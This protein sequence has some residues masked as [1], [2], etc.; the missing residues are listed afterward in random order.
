M[1]KKILKT[2]KKYECVIL[3]FRNK[4]SLIDQINCNNSYKLNNYQLKESF[5]HH[6]VQW[7]EEIKINHVLFNVSEILYLKD[8]YLFRNIL[9]GNFKG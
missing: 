5:N 2:E 6:N 1:C 9:L 4:N 3:L 7:R 8:L